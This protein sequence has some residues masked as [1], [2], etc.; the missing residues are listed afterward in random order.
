MTD[1]NR[2]REPDGSDEDIPEDLLKGEI[3]P[4][5]FLSIVGLLQGMALQILSALSDPSS[6]T[7]IH[8]SHAKHYIDCLSILDEKTRGNLS[9]DEKKLLDAVLTELRLAY[10]RVS[11][12]EKRSGP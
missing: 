12:E 3:P 7:E 4:A 9:E 8:P 2:K 1:E 10:V 11:P 6:R 5:T